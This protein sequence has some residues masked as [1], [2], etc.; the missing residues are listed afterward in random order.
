MLDYFRIFLYV[1]VL[2]LSPYLVLVFLEKEKGNRK[3][4]GKSSEKISEGG[5]MTAS[6]RLMLPLTTTTTTTA[7]FSSSSSSS[8]SF[9]SIFFQSPSPSLSSP[10][11]NPFNPFPSYYFSSSSQFHRRYVQG[12]R[13]SISSR[14]KVL[15]M[16]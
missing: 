16:D 1:S 6:W 13:S 11:P 2:F 10:N 4:E 3:R 8:S 14:C 15:L 7:I 12:K 9:S 5:G